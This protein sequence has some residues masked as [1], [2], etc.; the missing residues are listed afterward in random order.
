MKLK[1]LPLLILSIALLTPTLSSAQETNT[2]TTSMRSYGLEPGRSYSAEVVYQ[3]ILSLAADS[4][5]AVKSAFDEGYKAGLLDAAPQADFWAVIAKEYQTTAK[6]QA[7]G[8]TWGT[9]AIGTGTGFIIGA[10]GA[11]AAALILAH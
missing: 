5:A 1:I 6:A 2:P 8:P 9:V 4:K 3:L 7:R 10:A 11:L